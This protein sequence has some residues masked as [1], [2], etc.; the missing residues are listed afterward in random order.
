[1]NHILD[2]TPTSKFR[3]G[4]VFGCTYSADGDLY[5]AVLVDKEP[6]SK[7]KIQF[8]DF[9]NT[10]IKGEKELFCIPEDLALEPS[11][12]VPVQV[13]CHLEDNEENRRTVED[14]LNKENIT[15]LMKGGKL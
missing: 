2:L 15:V 9:G 12:A 13:F 3:R 11:A 5:R 1:M 14:A 6:D 7:V 8:I 10:E 4:A